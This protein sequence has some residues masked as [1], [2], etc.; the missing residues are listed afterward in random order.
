MPWRGMSWVA[1]LARMVRRSAPEVG[2]SMATSG[3]AMGIMLPGKDSTAG[4]LR[5][6]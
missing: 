6:D 2:R 1:L 4:E 3:V 5:G